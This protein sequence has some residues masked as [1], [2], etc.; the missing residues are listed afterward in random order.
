MA[1]R[2][3]LSLSAEAEKSRKRDAGSVGS[4]FKDLA[5]D[6]DKHWAMLG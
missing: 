2:D 5:D 4:G 1:S 3:A 6:L